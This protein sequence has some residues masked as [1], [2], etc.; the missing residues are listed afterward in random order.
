M[1]AC[2][3]INPTFIRDD[4]R[5][6][7]REYGFQAVCMAVQNDNI[8]RYSG[9]ILQSRINRWGAKRDKGGQRSGYKST[10]CGRERRTGSQKYQQEEP[11]G[12][13]SHEMIVSCW[14]QIIHLLDLF[15]NIFCCIVTTLFQPFDYVPGQACPLHRAPPHPSILRNK[16]IRARRTPGA[17]LVD[18][19]VAHRVM[20]P[21]VDNLGRK[22]PGRQ[23]FVAA[24]K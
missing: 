8:D 3:F 12:Y 14:Q 17:C 7:R 4:C 15:Y 1:A 16:I 23:D 19:Q 2:G 5:F 22:R 6:R 13:F 18:R 11:S 24:G 10:R 21:G 20:A 9:G